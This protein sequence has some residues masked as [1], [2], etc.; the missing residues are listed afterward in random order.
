MNQGKRWKRNPKDL[1]FKVN[2]FEP[3]KKWKEKRHWLV[4][5]QSSEIII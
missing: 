2:S 5:L 1:F 3:L 4:I